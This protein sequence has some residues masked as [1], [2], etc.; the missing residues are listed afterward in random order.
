MPVVGAAVAHHAC[1]IAAPKLSGPDFDYL[2]QGTG[3]TTWAADAEAVLDSI[4]AQLTLAS[5]HGSCKV[6]V[7]LETLVSDVAKIP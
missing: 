4:I 2:V 3:K 1:N 6:P 5:A 7:N